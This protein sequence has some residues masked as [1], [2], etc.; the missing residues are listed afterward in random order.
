MAVMNFDSFSSTSQNT[1]EAYNPVRL[2]HVYKE[3]KVL[4]DNKGNISTKYNLGNI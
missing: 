2:L 3:F 4:K 1:D